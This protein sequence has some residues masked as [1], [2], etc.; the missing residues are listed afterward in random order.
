MTKMKMA[1][2]PALLVLQMIVVP[3]ESQAAANTQD[4]ADSLKPITLGFNLG[5]LLVGIIILITG[6]LLFKIQSRK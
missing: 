3:V 6:F 4:I 5:M 1:L 2:L